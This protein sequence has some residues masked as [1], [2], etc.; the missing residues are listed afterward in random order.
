MDATHGYAP[1]I[2]KSPL[3]LDGRH[4]LHAYRAGNL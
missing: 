4:L 1:Q 3:K 2:L